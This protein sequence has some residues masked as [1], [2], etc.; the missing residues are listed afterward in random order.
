M[1]NCQQQLK[2]L[3][4]IIALAAPALASA[5]L[6]Q[7]SHFRLD[8]NA[9]DN[10]GGSG[11]SSSY[12]LTDSGGT[13]VAGA[14][15]SQSYKL[16]QGYVAQLVHSISLSVMPSGTV[17]YYPLDTGSGTQAYD[18]ST[19]EN[20]AA[21]TGSP[22]WVTGKVGQGISLNGSSQYA[23]AVTSSSLSQTGS[24]TVEAW[25]NLTDYA[26]YNSILTKTTGNG[27][28]NNTYELRT[29]QTTGKLQF[30]GFDSALRT[31]T[32]GVAVGTSGWHHVAATKGGG[33]VKLYIDGVQQGLGSVGTTTS[34][35]NAA[36][37]GARDDLAAANYFKGSLDEVR[38]F[39]RTLTAPEVAGDYTAGASGLEFA[40]TLPNVTPGTSSTYSTD[41]IVRTD[42]GGYNLLIQQ[43]GL[44]T[45]TDTTTTLPAI[46]ATIASPA[47][48]VEGTTK[49]FGFTV[50]SG[51]QVEAKWGT[52]PYNYAAVPSTATAYHSRT[53]LGGGVPEK[54]TLQFRADTTP[55]QKQ[56]TYS[57]TIVY[58]ATIKP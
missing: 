58:T 26:N 36:K 1:L 27:A 38:L 14:G 50:T 23:S 25:V 7:S 24:L 53:G 18:V 40:H 43:P 28:A 9:T 4:L 52:S 17:A 15:S 2:A 13:A 3:I 21:L 44:L 33:T 35:S 22:S 5:N 10:F 49:G 19:N 16:T 42:A 56:G 29:E 39:D 34:N 30:L 32:T 57:A 41:A 46:I 48:W 51:T 45:H 54:T 55:S 11:G 47:A 12:K 6:L 20:N 31:V 8:P 37:L